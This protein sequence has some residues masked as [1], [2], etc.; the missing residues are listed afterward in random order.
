MTCELFEISINKELG[1]FALPPQTVW[2]CSL[3]QRDMTCCRTIYS[4]VQYNRLGPAPELFRSGPGFRQYQQ[5]TMNL[6]HLAI[7]LCLA[8]LCHSGPIVLAVAQVA[9]VIGGEAAGLA[10]AGSTIAAAFGVGVSGIW[11]GSYVIVN[12]VL[13]VSQKKLLSG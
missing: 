10:V 13:L 5:M 2:N 11:F 12:G 4:T 3:S 7:F 1:Q 8:G 6:T 9:A